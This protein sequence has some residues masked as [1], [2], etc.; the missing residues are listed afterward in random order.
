MQCLLDLPKPDTGLTSLQLFYDTFENHIRGLAALGQLQ[1]SYGSLLI[2][3]ILG[4]LPA[5]IRRS[6]AREHCHLEWTIDQLRHALLKEIKILEAG[7]NI[8]RET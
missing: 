3:I 5:D 1:E 4:K 7:L 2:P 8:D 6:L